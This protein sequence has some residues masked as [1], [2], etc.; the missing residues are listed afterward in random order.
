MFCK[1]L[2]IKHV[3][4]LNLSFITPRDKKTFTKLYDEIL[5]KICDLQLLYRY[6]NK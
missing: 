3:L 1:I 6:L 4:Y 2:V 5:H